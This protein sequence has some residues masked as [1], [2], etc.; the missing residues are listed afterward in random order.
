[1]RV[2]H[3]DDATKLFDEVTAWGCRQAML[4]ANDHVVLVTGSGV[5]EKAHN[6]LVVHTITAEKCSI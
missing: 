2:S 1:L 3:L 6:L 4:K 5:M